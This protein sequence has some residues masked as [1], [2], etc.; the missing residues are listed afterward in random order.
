MHTFGQFWTKILKNGYCEIG[1]VANEPR[2]GDQI[3]AQTF[4]SE[5]KLLPEFLL[6]NSIEGDLTFNFFE[7]VFKR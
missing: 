3:K 5:F 4:G 6:K 2:Q 7:V 1:K